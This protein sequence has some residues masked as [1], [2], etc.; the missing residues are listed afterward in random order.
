AGTRPPP[1]PAAPT[2]RHPGAAMRRARRRGASASFAALH[3]L[4]VGAHAHVERAL[5]LLGDL[6]WPVAALVDDEGDVRLFVL[7]D[8]DDE[9]ALGTVGDAILARGAAIDAHGQRVLPRRGEA[10]VQLERVLRRR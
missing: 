1:A 5:A 7:G 6:G 2:R 10:I 8:V 4:D 3:G 9:G